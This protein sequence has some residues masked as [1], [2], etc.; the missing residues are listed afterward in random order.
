MF[1]AVV[2]HH[3]IAFEIC[4]LWPLFEVLPHNIFYPRLL[5]PS[6]LLIRIFKDNLK[7]PDLLE[8]FYGGK[9]EVLFGRM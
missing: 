6:I 5:I 7:Y 9:S 8:I 4:S 2:H 3:L 1:G